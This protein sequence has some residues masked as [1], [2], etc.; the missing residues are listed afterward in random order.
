MAIASKHQIF[1]LFGIFLALASG[2]ASSPTLSAEESQSM[3]SNKID[4]SILDSMDNNG[5][6]EFIVFLANQ[7][8]LTEAD[9]LP[10]K[11]EK[12]AYVFNSLTQAALQD[13][14][15]LLEYLGSQDAHYRSYWV[16]NMIWVSGDSHL[17]VDLASRQDVA[18]L[19]ANP[20]IE[21]KLPKP[22][23][24]ASEIQLIETAEWNISQIRVPEVWALG[25]TGQDVVIGGQDTGFD[26]THPALK[27]QYRGWDG[28][29]VTHDYNWYDAIH[30][31]GGV[32]GPDSAEPCDDLGHGTHTMGIMVGNNDGSR[33]FSVAPGAQWIGCRNMDRGAGTPKTYSDCYEWFIAPTD[34]DGNN[35][36]PSKAPHI[37]NNSWSCPPSEG[38][39]DINI[40]RIVVENVR[41]AGI[42]P[43]HA[44]GNDGFNNPRCGTINTP[45]AIYDASFTVGASTS[46]EVI[47]GFSSLGPATVDGVPSIKPDVVAPGQ[48]VYSTLPG[49]SYGTKSGTSMAAPH[50]AGLAALAISADPSL[51]D[52]IDRLELIITRMS[53]PKTSG[54]TCGGI[55]GMQVPNNTYGYGRID[56]LGSIQ[57]VINPK[58]Y[59]P[60]F[61]PA[62]SPTSDQENG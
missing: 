5:Q 25:Y 14:T 19:Y 1:L 31:G 23:K 24:I 40:L 45:A 43:V 44:A 37:I 49:G 35:P 22:G 50:V 6:I 21:L 11:A 61:A 56:G 46:A 8:D 54:E 52:N 28:Q 4:L 20:R 62:W 26:W 39:T 12:G 13:Q 17:L 59:L 27:E 32:C 48:N 41:A 18:H 58:T 7:A 33:N 42:L 3:L 51:A 15:S 2:A 36:D 29:T 57:L 47:A 55:S 60:I 30:A 16:A 10:T 53:I 9:Y 34:K 38:C